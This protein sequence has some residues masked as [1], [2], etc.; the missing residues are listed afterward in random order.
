MPGTTSFFFV[1]RFINSQL[2]I[3][4]LLLH[5]SDPKLDLFNFDTN[6]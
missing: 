2:D 3:G 4:Q 1:L 5:L 6:T